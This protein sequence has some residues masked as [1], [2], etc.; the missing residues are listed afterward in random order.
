VIADL[1]RS[2]TRW[3]PYIEVELPQIQHVQRSATRVT[4]TVGGNDVGFEEILRACITGPG[5]PGAHDCQHKGRPDHPAE[6]LAGFVQA[7]LR[8]LQNGVS[9]DLR[10]ADSGTETKTLAD[11]Y[12]NIASR[13][14]N[15]E[16]RANRRCRVPGLLRLRD[17]T[18]HE[19]RR[20]A[21]R[22]GVVPVRCAHGF[23][24]A[25]DD[26]QWINGLARQGNVI[27]RSEVRK[28][29]AQL[30]A[31]RPDV[32]IRYADA[33]AKWSDHRLCDKGEH[34]LNGLQLAA[35]G[36]GLPAVDDNIIGAK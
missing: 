3:S 10:S 22:P 1:Y 21:R 32:T 8:A 12:F 9:F 7:N 18:L 24:V 20:K 4:L 23:N 25:Y 13:M 34:W 2:N 19:G 6:S 14:A 31:A 27:I 17:E 29:L 35:S 5:A 30:A 26:A 36:N 16:W 11:V 33:D 28:A 15:G